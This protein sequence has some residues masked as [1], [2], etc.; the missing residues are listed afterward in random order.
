M[1]RC[2]PVGSPGRSTKPARSRG[3]SATRSWSARPTCSVAGPCRSWTTRR[4]AALPRRVAA[5]AD[6]FDGKVPSAANLQAILVDRF[7]EGAIEIDV[8]AVFDGEELFVGGVLEHIEEAGVHSGDSACTLP[9]ITLGRGQEQ[10]D[11]AHHGGHRAR[12]RGPWAAQR[13]VRAEGR[14]AVVHRGQPARVPDGAVRL[15][16]DRG[17]A[18]QGRRTRDGGASL[19]TLRDEGLIPAQDAVR[20][21]VRRTSRSRRPCCR[22]TGSRASTRCSVPR[23][24][25][26]ARSWA[27]TSTSVPR[28]PSR[29]PAPDRWCCPPRAACSCRSPTATS[30]PS[31]SRSCAW[32]TSGSTSSRPRHGR[33]PAACGDPGAGRRQGLAGGRSIL[34]LI[35]SAGDRAR[36]QH[37]V[38]LGTRGDGYEIRQAAVT[39]GVPC[40]T[41]LAGHP[42]GDPRGRGAASRAVDRAIVAEL[43]GRAA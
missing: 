38:R 6:L 40:I 39:N 8:D 31:C 29:R 34:D 5:A 4:P 16:G 36:A 19:A 22:S 13:A 24:A 27:S 37:P 11:P 28:S 17:A 7:L 25:P 14:R 30:G 32:S 26:P 15:Q 23:C 2:P 12:A 43:P 20:G 9:P 35:E 41:T 1:S 42:G 3:G 21:P 10:R 18:G 33:R